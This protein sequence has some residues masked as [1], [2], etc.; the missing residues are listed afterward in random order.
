MNEG[1]NEEPKPKRKKR[2]RKKKIKQ[3]VIKQNE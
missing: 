3:L 1:N 2:G